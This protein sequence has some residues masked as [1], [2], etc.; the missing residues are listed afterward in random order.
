MSDK[1]SSRRSVLKTS[2]AALAASVGVIGASGTASANVQTIEIEGR[3]D[4][5]ADYDIYVD[6]PN[7]RGVSSTLESGDYVDSGSSGS[8]LR[9]TVGPNDVD[10]YEFEGQVIEG[11]TYGS[12]TFFVVNANG[13]NRYPK[14]DVER[15]GSPAVDYAFDTTSGTASPTSNCESDDS[16]ESGSVGDGDDIDTWQLDGVIDAYVVTGDPDELVIF[17]QY[18]F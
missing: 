11:G 8:F 16:N 6:D 18:D 7:A 9:G 12:L 4:Y 17:K 3:G 2:G 15:S 10:K 14:F 5:A 1:T 13:A